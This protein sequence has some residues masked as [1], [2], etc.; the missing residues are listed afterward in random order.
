MKLVASDQLH[1]SSVKP[2]VIRP[3]EEFE[4]SEELGRSLLE[5]FPFLKRVDVA[6][7]VKAQMA[8]SNKAEV[9]PSN[10]A[11]SRRPKAK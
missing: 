7:A 11:A 3:G 6:K 1:I 9:D 8:P 2:D 5:R 4:V 10:K